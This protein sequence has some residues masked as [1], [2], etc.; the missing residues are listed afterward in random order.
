MAQ[1]REGGSVWDAMHEGLESLSVPLP[2][3]FILLF[4]FG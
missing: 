3:S 4:Y 2:M 1:Q